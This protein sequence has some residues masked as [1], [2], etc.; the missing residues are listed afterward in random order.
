M[1]N[2]SQH[3]GSIRM[4]ARLEPEWDKSGLREHGRY[5]PNGIWS[6]ARDHRSPGYTV[7]VTTQ[8]VE[9]DS[10]EHSGLIPKDR[11]E[12]SAELDLEKQDFR[13]PS[14]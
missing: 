12:D 11:W 7:P 1:T 4:C 9:A 2:V 14:L 13:C 3:V 5:M 8:P 6:L 10:Q